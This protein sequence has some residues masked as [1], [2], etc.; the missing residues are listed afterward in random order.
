MTTGG[1]QMGSH[2]YNTMYLLLYAIKHFDKDNAKY[3]KLRTQY[4]LPILTKFRKEGKISLEKQD[5]IID[6]LNSVN[7]EDWYLAFI[8]IRDLE[9]D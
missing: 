6:M 5:N 2:Y 1:R 4:L 9:S 3:Y 8:L 7:R